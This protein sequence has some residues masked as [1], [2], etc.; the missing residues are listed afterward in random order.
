MQY[1][2][3]RLLLCRTL[4]QNL[5][6]EEGDAFV[7]NLIQILFCQ[8]GQKNRGKSTGNLAITSNDIMKTWNL[9]I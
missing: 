7:N 3:L 8:S 2:S 4:L 5:S 6:K 1:N 9:C